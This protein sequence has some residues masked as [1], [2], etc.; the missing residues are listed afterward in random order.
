ML[1]S[2]H[3]KNHSK[4]GD[5]A[6]NGVL[7]NISK[8]SKGKC[9]AISDNI[10]VCLNAIMTIER[11][12]DVL[13]STSAK[14]TILRVVGNWFV[15]EE[16]FRSWLKFHL[17]KLS[18]NDLTGIPGL[19]SGRL[20]ITLHHLLLARR[21]RV[22]TS[23]SAI[24]IGR[25][26]RAFYDTPRPLTLWIGLPPLQPELSTTIE[27]RNRLVA[28]HPLRIPR[29]ISQEAGGDPPFILEEFINGRRFGQP[30]DW[31]SL[32]DKLLK[33]LFQLYDQGGIRHR[34][35]AEVYDKQWIMMSM[36]DLILKLKW[37]KT[38][39]SKEQ[40]MK[41]AEES[42]NSNEE[43]LPLCIG[44]G[45]L[46]KSNLLIPVDGGIAL[47]DWERSQELPV[48]ADLVKLIC[49]YHP[50]AVSIEP[51]L[52]QRTEDFRNMSPN[53]QLL[54]ATFKRIALLS[55]LSQG[56]SDNWAT[57]RL[58]ARKAQLWLSLATFL[59]KTQQLRN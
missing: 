53:R 49:R 6:L 54:L 57:R 35:V 55:N 23:A 11:R 15:S 14:E 25:N 22:H 17:T 28:N 8:S 24:F 20:F 33:P 38:W 43:T 10:K 4:P 31:I 59:T 21:V 16:I 58:T 37:K 40:L 52:L 46:G 9:Q 3:L 32:A 48:A 1:T 18:G 26:V 5:E 51:E 7:G 36:A 30:E 13:S 47:L 50:L 41:S 2:L 42:L 44:H 27:I 56:D 12:L 39:L 45:D 19:M 29:I 34:Q